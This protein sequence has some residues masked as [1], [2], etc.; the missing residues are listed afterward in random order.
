MNIKDIT[1]KEASDLIRDKKISPVELTKAFL[2]RIE[3]V[4]KELNTYITVLSEHALNTAE[5]AEKEIMKGNY[6][7]PLHGVPIGLKDIF[8]MKDVAATCGSKMLENFISPYDATVTARI[9]KS[10]AVILGKN[11]MDEFAMGSSNET[12][13]FG[14]VKNPWNTG[15]VPGGSSGGSASAAAA[16]LC[17]A[18]IGT[19]TGGSIRQPAALCGITGLKP[20][21]GR[22]S[23]YGMIAFASSLD[24]AGPLTKSV[25]DA[26]IILNAISGRDEMDSTS[27]DIEVPD[28][29]KKLNGDIKGMKIGIP[30]E[31]FVDGMDSEVES[32]VLKAIKDIE[33]LGAEIIEIS[34]PHTKYAISTYYIIAPCEASS[35]LARYDGVR[36]GYRAPDV[37]NLNDLFIR[38]RSE[39]FGEEVKRRIMLGTYALSSGYYDAYYLKA[40]KVRTLIREDFKNAWEKV[41]VIVTPTTPETAFGIN[42]K[43][44]DPI[45]MYL[46]DVLTIPCNIA[47]IPGLSTPCGFSSGNLPIGLQILGKSFDEESILRVAHAYE[48]VNNWN[49]KTP[50]I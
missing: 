48:K 31:Y 41:D 32:A 47:G 36:Y 30:K 19:D 13:Y 34:L 25:E 28:F 24:Q 49:L 33:S 12:S 2:E 29:T 38:S 45:K 3:T 40:Q 5:S 17:T 35:N 15:K 23:R 27:V 8:V 39:G 4:D 42:E 9:K 50:E 1:I 14:P 44:D 7:G 21:Y 6:L 20:T 11:N 43:T 18:S 26:A 22:V 10:G 16:G 37:D 46:S